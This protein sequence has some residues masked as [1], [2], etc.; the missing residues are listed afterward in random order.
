MTFRDVLGWIAAVILAAFLV[1]IVVSACPGQSWPDSARI[2]AVADSAGVDRRVALAIAW[3]ET[4]DNTSPKVRGHACWYV[5][6]ARVDTAVAFETRAILWVKSSVVD[7]VVTI[8][9]RP[10]VVH[11]E[12]NCEV[13]RYQIKPSTARRRCPELDVFTYGGNLACFV[14]MFKEDAD[15]DGKLYAITHHNGSGAKAREYLD[16]VLR[17]V[18]RIALAEEGI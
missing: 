8:T 5:I 1:T 18:G 15:G 11:H 17:T 16:R 9:H 4:A 10:G 13:G 14:R 6:K 2:A 3:E 12:K 7:T